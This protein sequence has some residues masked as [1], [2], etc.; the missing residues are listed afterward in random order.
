M[1]KKIAAVVIVLIA[2]LVGVSYANAASPPQQAL[3]PGVV[4]GPDEGP[5][6]FPEV[7]DPFS[8][9]DSPFPCWL[10]N[11]TQEPCE[12]PAFLT[13]SASEQEKI[14]YVL[15]VLQEINPR[16]VG[17]TEV[18]FPEEST[19]PTTTSISDNN[20]CTADCN[21][22]SDFSWF[23]MGVALGLSFIALIVSF[24]AFHKK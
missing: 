13:G 23:L 17:M 18:E 20:Q 12:Y 21:S 11:F 1:K 24:K 8:I 4:S 10:V 5:L 16:Y 3:F 14:A 6:T 7:P 2:L 9:E 19:S 22:D 15:G